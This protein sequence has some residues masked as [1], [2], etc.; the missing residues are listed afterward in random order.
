MH[1]ST[2]LHSFDLCV[3]YGD[4]SVPFGSNN[5]C[6]VTQSLYLEVLNALLEA[7]GHE[8]GGVVSS[9]D[10]D[11]SLQLCTL[12]AHSLEVCN[13]CQNKSSVLQHARL[14]ATLHSS[15]SAHFGSHDESHDRSHDPACVSEVLL[16][17]L[18]WT[19]EPLVV[20]FILEKRS[21]LEGEALLERLVRRAMN[22]S[23]PDI[24]SLVSLP[25]SEG[26]L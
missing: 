15:L 22:D 21:L 10:D 12:H 17:V 26:S 24:L 18:S 25:L 19:K 1:T 23:D 16:G 20:S 11:A 4:V 9:E 6:A 14:L 13:D 3:S 2:Y 5:S 8:I 7:V